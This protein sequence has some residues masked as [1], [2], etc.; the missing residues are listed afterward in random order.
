MLELVVTSP[1]TNAW[2][3]QYIQQPT[4]ENTDYLASSEPASQYKNLYFDPRAP[5]LGGYED[6]TG[7]LNF[8][9]LET[10]PQRIRA[11]GTVEPDDQKTQPPHIDKGQQGNGQTGPRL[12]VPGHGMK[13]YPTPHSEVSDDRPTMPKMALSSTE[14]SPSPGKGKVVAISDPEIDEKGVY[15]CSL[16]ECANKPREFIR[17]CEYT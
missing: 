8:L 15:H 4:S 3:S 1:S 5:N 10:T 11:Q 6:S 2:T 16:E 17:K 13:D 14:G 7:H 9:D 12:A